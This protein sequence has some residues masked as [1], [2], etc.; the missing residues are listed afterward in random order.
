MP[1]HNYDDALQSYEIFSIVVQFFDENYEKSAAKWQ[2]LVA[3]AE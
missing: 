2:S 1:N 3:L